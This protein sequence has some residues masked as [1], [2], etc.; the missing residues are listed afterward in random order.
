MNKT[1]IGFSLL[2]ITLIGGGIALST[3][4]S[5]CGKANTRS[6]INLVITKPHLSY[7]QDNDGVTILARINAM[8]NTNLTLNVDVTITNIT[9]NTATIDGHGSFK[10]SIEVYFAVSK[11][12]SNLINITD[13]GYIS[14]STNYDIVKR[15]NELNGTRFVL[16][17][18]VTITASAS[19]S[20]TIN[21]TSDFTGSI[22]LT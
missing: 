7:I 15:V 3:S 18:N 20:A 19:D 17:I 10:N 8:N 14:N 11:N 2:G 4:L 12:I 5:S 6:D 21:G 9:T 13:L 22:G 16:D 1:K